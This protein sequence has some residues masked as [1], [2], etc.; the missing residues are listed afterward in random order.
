MTPLR[1]RM[2]EDMKLRNY[3][4]LTIKV[5]VERV[6]TFAQHFGKSPRR[7]GAA[8]VRAYLLF[9][10]QEKH[11]SWSY[12][13]QALAALRFLYRTTLGKEWVLDGV[14]SPRKPKKLPVVL[15]PA[16]VTQFFEAVAGLKH[17]AIL[18]TAYAAGL[19][20]SEVV[21]LCVDD[22]DSRRMVI[23]IRQAKG[24][25]DRYVMLS[26][27]LLAILREYWKADRPTQ[28]LFPGN[29]PDRPIT[30][31]TVE[32][33][34][35][36]ARA[37]AGLGKHVTVHTLRHSFATHLL[38]A[39]T[40]IRIIQVLLGH[41]SLRTTAVYTHVSAATLEATQ[42]PFDRLAPPTEGRPQP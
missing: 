12:Y 19:R 37:A 35:R 3:A 39:G 10:V 42:S 17:R 33:A 38:E 8:D 31:R 15:S 20:V 23:R 1:Q 26:P 41:R 21:A 5:Y 27:R 29:V 32:K 6:A 7:L 40:D 16:E 24:Q 4:P 11:A 28:F 2:L 30:P 34:C 36:D 22:I 9:L 25:K 13:G 18:M 14:V